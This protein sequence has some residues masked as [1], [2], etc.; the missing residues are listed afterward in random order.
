MNGLA[1]HLISENIFFTFCWN[2]TLYKVRWDPLAFNSQQYEIMKI[3]V[4]W[5]CDTACLAYVSKTVLL[6]T[7]S[8]H[9]VRLKQESLYL[10]LTVY[11]HSGKFKQILKV[12]QLKLSPLFNWTAEFRKV[13]DTFI[14]LG[15]FI[16]Y[17]RS[18]LQHYQPQAGPCRQASRTACHSSV[19]HHWATFYYHL[20]TALGFW[21]AYR[22]F[23]LARKILSKRYSSV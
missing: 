14:S 9:K 1:P 3:I 10:V 17:L 4:C 6:S 15:K 20:H 22:L 13:S 7:H 23:P 18:Q 19:L 8:P 5:G 11:L 12:N 2:Q 21:T 16:I